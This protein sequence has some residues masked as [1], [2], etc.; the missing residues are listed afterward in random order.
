ML[1][2][3][4]SW[5]SGPGCRSRAAPGGRRTPGRR[6]HAGAFLLGSRESQASEQARCGM[7]GTRQ[8]GAFIGRS[9]A[10]IVST[11]QAMRVSGVGV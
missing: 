10:G 8:P 2:S 1:P 3:S 11:V 4:T 7:L 9:F 6:D 5:I